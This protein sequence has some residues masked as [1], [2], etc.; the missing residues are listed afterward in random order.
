M[1]DMQKRP[2]DIDRESEEIIEETMKEIF[3]DINNS[4]EFKEMDDSYEESEEAADESGQEDKAEEE[5]GRPLSE[6]TDAGDLSSDDSDIE[7]AGVEEEPDSEDEAAEEEA[8]GDN[9]ESDEDDFEPDE[10]DVESNEDDFEPGEDDV[11]SNEDDFESDEDDGEEEE[12]E[13]EKELRRHR[14]RKKAGII[15]ASVA[16]AL[17]LIYIGFAVFF[18]SHFIFFTEINGQDFSM[19]SVSQVEEYMK[20]QVADYVLTLKESD[21][22]TETIRGADI[23]LEYV[24]GKELKQLVKKQNNFLWIESLWKHP[25]I[26]AEVGVKYDENALKSITE[27]LKCLNPDNQTASVDAHPEF[28]DTEFVIVPEVIGTQIDT[29]KFNEAV[30]TAIKGFVSSVD[31]ADAGCYI[32]PRFVSDSKEV[33]AAKD[34]MNSYL[35][36][37]VTYDF[38]PNTEVVDASV[39]S[40]WVKVDADMNVT[41]DEE[42]V[43][44]YIQTLADKYNTKGKTRTFTTA[45]GNS[46]TVE[47]GS[48]GWR[49]DQEAEYNALTANIKNGETVTREPEY[50]S[51]AAS[52]DVNDFGNT[53]AEVDL[54]NQQMYFI[55]NGQVVLQTGIVTGNPNKGNGTPQGTYS[56]AYKALDQVL[57]GKKKPDGT[58]EYESPV[59]FWMP[60]NGGIGFHDATW[61]PTFGGSRYQ[62]NGSH[63]CVNMPY[64]K[65]AQ[66][67][68]LISAGTPVILHY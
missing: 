48:Y 6:D 65:A 22:G 63:G 40:Q 35:G 57:R 16:G 67:Y 41:F 38:S 37:S 20:K 52:H 33:T 19:K 25:E 3:D 27:N 13:A 17:I 31:L 49:I 11:E 10:D 60:F 55:Q 51:R 36:A 42:A 45:G 46:V 12:T 4:D 14:R 61:Q 9:D 26:T 2:E 32:K 39:I 28:K 15:A 44:A 23:S 24:Q 59:K 64:D 34:A 1:S 58:Y 7:T 8:S 18:S 56:L 29:E 21:G 66:L 47:G 50:S 68:D 30:S 43:K 54:T 62:T 5:N 53:Y